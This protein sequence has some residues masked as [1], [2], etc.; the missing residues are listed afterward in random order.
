MEKVKVDVMFEL[1]KSEVNVQ[2]AN[3]PRNIEY[4]RVFDVVKVTGNHHFLHGLAIDE[5]NG[6]LVV[7]LV[8]VT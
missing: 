7:S 2:A 8:S 6:R 4:H 3:R 1:I 5:W